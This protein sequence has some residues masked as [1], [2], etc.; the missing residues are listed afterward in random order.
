MRE[1]LVC[2]I[3][4]DSMY[5]CIFSRDATDTETLDGSESA[6]PRMFFF[7]LQLQRNLSNKALTLTSQYTSIQSK[8]L[9]I[10]F[11]LRITIHWRH[12]DRRVAIQ[13]NRHIN[14]PAER[15]RERAMDGHRSVKQIHFHIEHVSRGLFAIPCGSLS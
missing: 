9:E 15:E 6:R 11:S 7:S 14:G 3:S 12:R 8:S 5:G 1:E 4:A 13:T 2:L 10:M